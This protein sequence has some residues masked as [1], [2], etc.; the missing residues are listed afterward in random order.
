M[1]SLSKSTNS[2]YRGLSKSSIRG[3]GAWS[4]PGADPGAPYTDEKLRIPTVSELMAREL[5]GGQHYTVEQAE[6]LRNDYRTYRLCWWAGICGPAGYNPFE[7]Y[8]QGVPDYS[9]VNLEAQRE[10]I[11]GQ[12]IGSP[13]MPTSGGTAVSS[14][15]GDGFMGDVFGAFDSDTEGNYFT[16]T[17][18]SAGSMATSVLG[19]SVQ[20]GGM[21][22]PI[23]LLGVVG[24]GI[25]Y[26]AL[27]K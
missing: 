24:L 3:L 10:I 2:L 14:P 6:G 9:Q 4:G 8:E 5:P 1:L 27:K 20:A 21:N 18:G 7:P 13:P 17:I 15:G 25:G 23:W 26:V 22:I 19:G 16:D 12:T 11:A